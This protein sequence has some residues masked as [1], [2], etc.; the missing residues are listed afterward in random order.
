MLEHFLGHFWGQ[1]FGFISFSLGIASFWQTDDRRLKLIMVLL[2]IC[3][4]IHYAFFAAFTSMVSSLL[5]TFRTALSMRTRSGWVAFLFIVSNLT[6]GL[7]IA[8]SWSD[9]W[10]VFGMCIGT[11]ALFRLKGLTMR[12]VFLIGS[13]CWLINNIIVGSIGGT[14]LEIM[15]LL[16][17]LSTMFRI[18]KARQATVHDSQ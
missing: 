14:M 2:N 8:Q 5:S 12:F 17:N 1:L 4:T 11:Y 6:L 16:I 7:Y 18:F 10:P 15:M 3:N 13:G 9:L